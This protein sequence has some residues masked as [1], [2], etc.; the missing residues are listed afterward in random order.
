MA[1][2]S[3][4]K[5]ASIAGTPVTRAVSPVPAS[6]GSAIGA[7]RADLGRRG[8]GFGR[9]GADERQDR[10]APLRAERLCRRFPQRLGQL[11]QRLRL[12]VPLR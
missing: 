6:S 7:Q 1:K 11:R 4:S 12:E 10:D 9:I 5:S 8:A 2:I 3:W